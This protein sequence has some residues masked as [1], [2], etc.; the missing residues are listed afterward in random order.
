MLP[1]DRRQ[2]SVGQGSVGQGS[3][4]QGSAGQGSVTGKAASRGPAGRP[5]PVTAGGQVRLVTLS[6][7]PDDAAAGAADSADSAARSC[8][9]RCFEGRRITASTTPSPNSAAEVVKASL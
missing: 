5:A 4:G 3:A 6:S 1:T 2:G 7:A 9:S 8:S